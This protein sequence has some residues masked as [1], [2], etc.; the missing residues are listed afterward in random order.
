MPDLRQ[1]RALRAVADA[2]SFSGAAGALNHTQP[3]VSKTIANLEREM[4]AVLVEREC[5]PVRLT[6]AGEALA[7]HAGEMFAQLSSARSEIEATARVDAGTVS[8]GTFSS[9]GATFLG[10]AV[11]VPAAPSRGPGVHLGGRTARGD[12]SAASRR[13]RPRDRLGPAGGRGGRGRASSSITRSTIPGSSSCTRLSP[14]A[15]RKRVRAAD[16]AGED[17]LLPEF[18]PDGPSRLVR[19][20]CAAA[21]FEPRVAY[22]VN[23][24]QMTKAM[25]AAGEGVSIIPR[26]MLDPAPGDVAIRPVADFEIARRVA[27]VRL[28]TRYL[29]PAV[30][31][32][33]R[34]PARPPRGASAPMAPDPGTTCERCGASFHC[35]AHEGACWCAQ[36]DVAPPVRDRLAATY[37]RC[38]CPACLSEVATEPLATLDRERRPSREDA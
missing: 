11:R 17:W 29:T 8:V 10:R 12:P 13:A 20:M 24:C 36:V 4:G 30:A 2:G 19:S 9:A 28:R 5:R 7:R 14:R 38:L 22:R 32:S 31:G 23:D 18:N 1:L 34:S 35:G 37:L 25:V 26:L 27:A 16:L 21:G 15:R 3:A 33:S 6:D